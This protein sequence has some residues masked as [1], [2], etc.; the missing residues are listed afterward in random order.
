MINGLIHFIASI[1]SPF[2]VQS[3]LYS[4]DWSNANYFNLLCFPSTAKWLWCFRPLL[5]NR[6]QM[7]SNFHNITV[8]FI[9]KWQLSAFLFVLLPQ[10][11]YNC[12]IVQNQLSYMVPR[13]N[14]HAHCSSLQADLS[15][16][17]WVFFFYENTEVL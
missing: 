3:F 4:L 13:I 17:S 8:G 7:L 2:F 16:F 11:T 5:F 15:F 14:I 12:N 10:L 9:S 6:R 1:F